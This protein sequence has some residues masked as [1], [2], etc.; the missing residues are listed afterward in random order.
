MTAVYV[1]I[2][3]VDSFTEVP[4]RGMPTFGFCFV[5]HPTP[6]LFLFL[7]RGLSFIRDIDAI[8]IGSLH[9]IFFSLT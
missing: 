5:G 8:S 9:R 7:D 4:F 3:T 2:Y 6:K 1:P